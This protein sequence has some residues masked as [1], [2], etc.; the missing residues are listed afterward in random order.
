MLSNNLDCRGGA[1]KAGP[2][3]TKTAPWHGYSH[4]RMATSRAGNSGRRQGSAG[5]RCP[6]LNLK[7]I[8]TSSPRR[9][10]ATSHQP[11]RHERKTVDGVLW[12]VHPPARG[13]PGASVIFYSW[14]IAIRVNARLA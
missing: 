2:R 6:F 4:H 8:K 11:G 13:I 3:W 10:V 5:A 7:A 14:Q 9:E 1:A 12:P